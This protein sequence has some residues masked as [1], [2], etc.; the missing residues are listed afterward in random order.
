VECGEK[1]IW[2][3]GLLKDVG[4]VSSSSEGKRMVKQGAVYVEGDRVES[5]QLEIPESGTVVIKVGK[6]KFIRVIFSA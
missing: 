3:P 4:M 1:E 5:E 6:R 2:L